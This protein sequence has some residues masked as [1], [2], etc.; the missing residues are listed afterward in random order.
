MAH[1]TLINAWT[2]VDAL[3][4]ALTTLDEKIDS[5]TEQGWSMLDDNR[6]GQELRDLQKAFDI[7][8]DRVVELRA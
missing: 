3:E 4:L 2:E 5:I 6:H 7:L 8:N 1:P